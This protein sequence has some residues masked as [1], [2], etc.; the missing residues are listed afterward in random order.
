[1]SLPFPS[2]SGLLAIKSSKIASVVSFKVSENTCYQKSIGVSKLSMQV[3]GC[4]VH[5][6][7]SVE[8]TPLQCIGHVTTFASSTSELFG[9]L[10]MI[11]IEKSQFG[12]F[13][14]PRRSASVAIAVNS[15][16]DLPYIAGAVASFEEFGVTYDVIIASA[17][18][19]PSRV[20]SFA[21]TASDQGYDVIIASGCGEPHL[22]SMIASISPI[23]VIAH[24]IQDVSLGCHTH[25]SFLPLFAHQDVSVG[26]VLCKDGRNAALLALR[27]I[28]S[29]SGSIQLRRRIKDHISKVESECLS[30]ALKL[31]SMGYAEF[32][33][34]QQHDDENR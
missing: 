34:A 8:C 12:N 31:E 10:E 26:S 13:I 28:S 2:D 33:K 18:L 11:G 3:S 19:T 24:I 20:Y 22:A 25:K 17:H 30:D 6:Y 7:G 27:I 15:K 32:I 4:H 14:P 16:E 23:P 5:H 1:M 21:E 9:K 29:N